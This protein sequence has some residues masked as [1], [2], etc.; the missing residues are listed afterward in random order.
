MLL[1]DSIFCNIYIPPIVFHVVKDEDGHE[2][3]VCVEGK[4]H[5]TSIVDFLTGSVYFQLP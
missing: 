4:E 5:L 1:I 2:I 3:C